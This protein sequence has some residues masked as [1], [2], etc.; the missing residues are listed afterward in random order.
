MIS[1]KL[2]KAI[3]FLSI[4]VRI[5]KQLSGRI[6]DFRLKFLSLRPIMNFLYN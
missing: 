2:N 1:V 4:I 5:D 6:K 3:N